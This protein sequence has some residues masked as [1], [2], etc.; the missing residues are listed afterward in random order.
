MSQEAIS[1]K[2]CV[3]RAF[4]LVFPYNRTSDALVHNDILIWCML[5]LF[6]FF[7]IIG[8]LMHL[9]IMTDNDIL[10]WCMLLLFLFFQDI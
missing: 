9:Y 8:H 7:P 4:V 10:I 6:L 1:K 3:S 5:L 2:G